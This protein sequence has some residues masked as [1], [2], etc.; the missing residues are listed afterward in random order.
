MQDKPGMVFDGVI[1]GVT[2]W[3]FN[4]LNENNVR[5]SYLSVI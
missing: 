4:E 3:D 2:E 5:D 1:S